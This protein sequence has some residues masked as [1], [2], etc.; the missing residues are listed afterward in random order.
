MTTLPKKVSME[1]I[2]SII[3]EE[4]YHVFPNTTVTV[5]LIKLKNNTNVVGYNYGAVDP[6]E[7]SFERGKTE[8]RA[9]AINKIWELETYLL[10]EAKHLETDRQNEAD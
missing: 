9:A 8:A 1:H 7:H 6:D 2:G 10:R 4:V 3:K 5:C